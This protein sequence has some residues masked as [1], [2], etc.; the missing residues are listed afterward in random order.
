MERNQEVL[1]SHKGSETFSLPHFGKLTIL[2][3]NCKKCGL[4]IVLVR[5]P[6]KR[7]WKLCVHCGFVNKIPKKGA[8]GKKAPGKKADGKRPAKKP[9]RKNATLKKPAKKPAKK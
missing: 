3:E 1:G 9:A 2:S 6:R 4:H 8:K 7:P 5:A